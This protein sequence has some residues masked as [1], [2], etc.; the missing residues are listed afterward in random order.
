MSYWPLDTSFWLKKRSKITQTLCFFIPFQIDISTDDN[1][2]GITTIL[3]TFGIKS[4]FVAYVRISRTQIK[5]HQLCQKREFNAMMTSKLANK[6]VNKKRSLFTKFLT[7]TFKAT[8]KIWTNFL[9]SFL[10]NLTFNKAFKFR[11]LNWL[12][13]GVIKQCACLHLYMLNTMAIKWGKS[14][15]S[16]N[17]SLIIFIWNSKIFYCV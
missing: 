7:L 10:P 3:W 1:D 2:I 8:N 13:K 11:K 12:L 5:Y 16:I 4:S 6:V 15:N 9:T 17:R 14:T